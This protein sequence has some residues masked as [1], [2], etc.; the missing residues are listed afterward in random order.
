MVFS[1]PWGLLALIS[2]PIIVGLHFFHSQR[3]VRRVGG[4]HLWEFAQIRIPAGR[5]LDRFTRSLPLL[6][7]LLAALL[8]SLLL[9]GFDIP[10]QSS[11][12]HYTIILDDSISMLAGT[13]ESSAARAV[14]LL[15]GIGSETDRFTLLTAGLRPQI[16]AGPFCEKS[17]MEAA[18]Q[19]WQ[20]RDPN[21]DI[22]AA[23]NLASKFIASSDKI[24]FL[25]DDE[26][27]ARRYTETLEIAAVGEPDDNIAIDYADR[28]RVS[29]EK[30]RIFVTLQTY[31]K[32]EQ[33]AHL[34]GKIAGQDVF[35][36]SI[37]LQPGTPLSLHVDIPY[38]TQTVTLSTEPDALSA[39]NTAILP[40]VLIKPVNVAFHA[41]GAEQVPIAKAVR[42]T[43]Y[44]EIVD[45]PEHANLVFSSDPNYPASPSNYRVCV[46]PAIDSQP[47]K[48]VHLAQGRDIVFDHN[49]PITES[50]PLEGVLWPLRELSAPPNS[51]P[52]LTWHN[53]PLLWVESQGRE[54][55]RIGI[56]LLHD[57]T[58]IF[59][60]ATWPILISALVED[61]RMAIPGLSKTNYR[62]GEPV[63]IR[64][65][66]DVRDER[67]Q[68]LRHDDVFETYQPLPNVIPDLPLG[69]YTLALSSGDP[70]A[71]FSVNLFAPGES[72]LRTLQSNT[73][74]VSNLVPAS[75]RQTERNRFLY[76]SLLIL[77]I[78]FT[79]ASWIYQDIS[80]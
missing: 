77:L 40:P 63:H 64:L 70:L 60:Q 38:L 51:H 44:T 62:V 39:D 3:Q 43:G 9:A 76:F 14:D 50:L 26:A 66:P 16:I 47:N 7:Q 71:E 72:D 13:N 49:S 17:E 20:P 75:I 59:Q 1:N 11:N 68:I 69:H 57:R 53:I 30:D 12:R 29:P 24:L 10:I 32:L 54:N 28:M 31:S 48:N 41:L 46:L 42:S 27:P 58:N 25:T 36:K 45:D 2:I 8:A 73:P 65:R 6:F 21:C 56:N 78:L 79:A 55:A 18:S 34:Y 80:H 15:S 5:R 22:E 61:C 4:L 23:V 19:Q 33:S 37:T 67:I 35:T 52:L 74:Q